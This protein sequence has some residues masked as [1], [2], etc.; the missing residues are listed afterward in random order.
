MYYRKDLLSKLPNFR[1]IKKNLDNSITWNNFIDLARKSRFGK[2]YYF[3]PADEY[4]GLICSYN[5][6]VLSADSTFYRSKIDFTKPA[7]IKA[8]KL[9]HDLTNKY[10]TSP[11]SVINFREKNAYSAFFENNGLFLRGWQSFK[12]DT[13][14]LDYSKS[15]EALLEVTMLP[16][17]AKGKKGSTIGG[18]NLMLANNSEH[19]KEAV[20]F[21][22]Y[23][24]KKESQKIM[25][26][27]G[28]YMPVTKE[29]YADSDFVT[30]YP[31]L[32]F[33]KKLLDNGFLRPKLM[34]YTKI[35]DVLSHYLR[36]TIAGELSPE[37]AMELT[38]KEIANSL[39]IHAEK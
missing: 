33:N 24:L 15:K 10:R 11:K 27:V 34:D 30:R 19:K 25:Y 16:H 18:W 32:R 2:N 23:F 9:L 13:K 26:S 31:D 39:G 37:K 6:L 3:F 14:N 36:L 1:L 12:K 7:S 35:S 29:V 5:D 38:Q 8:A 28:Y 22:K 20:V 4:E 21:M 17:F